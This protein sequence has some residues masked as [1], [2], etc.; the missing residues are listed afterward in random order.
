MVA[1]A[2][3]PPLG[4]ACCWVAG[5]GCCRPE[6]VAALAAEP[7]L[8]AACCWAAGV[9]SCRSGAGALLLLWLLPE[10]GVVRVPEAAACWVACGPGG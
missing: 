2:A 3:E 1:L 4:A 10:G 9:G 7:P 8:G 5:V 6:A